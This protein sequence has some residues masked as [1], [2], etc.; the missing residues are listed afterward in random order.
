VIETTGTSRSVQV[1]T[2]PHDPQVRDRGMQKSLTDL[3]TYVVRS[4]ERDLQLHCEY[5]RVVC[6]TRI[7]SEWKWVR[8]SSF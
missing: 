2:T 5:L 1:L 8:H 3:G 7:V 6:R 4:Q